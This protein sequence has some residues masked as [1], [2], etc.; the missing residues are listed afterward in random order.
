MKK[1]TLIFIVIGLTLAVTV[2]VIVMLF[3]SNKKPDLIIREFDASNYQWE[4]ENFPSEENV[5]QVD[6]ANTAIEKAKE[7]WIEKYSVVNGQPYDPINGRK[8]EVYFDHGSDCWLVTITLPS[9]IKGST[10]R[11]IIKKDGTVIAVWM[12]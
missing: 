4:I 2:A 12:G 9:N 7:L 8:C 3:Y 6:D 11:A 5:G 10:P 1:K